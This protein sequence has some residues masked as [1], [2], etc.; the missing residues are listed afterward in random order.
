VIKAYD[1]PKPGHPGLLVRFP[2]GGPLK[3][4]V[5]PGELV[6]E[7]FDEASRGMVVSVVG[8]R[9]VVLW[10]KVPVWLTVT[11]PQIRQVFVSSISQSLASVQPMSAPVGGVFFKE[12]TYGANP[13]SGS[14]G[15][16]Q[17]EET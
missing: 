11:L 1:R 17:G 15:S 10:S 7:K 6:R 5:A 16:K 8:D 4:D 14:L 2:T 9:V 3:P 12:F 13:P